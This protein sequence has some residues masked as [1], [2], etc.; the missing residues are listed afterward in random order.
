[1]SGIEATTEID[2]LRRE[3]ETV[4]AGSA[5]KSERLYELAE[6]CATLRQ[7][8]ERAEAEAD[9]FEA[10]WRKVLAGEH[11]LSDSYVRLR[12]ILGAMRPPDIH[13][14]SALWDYVENTAKEQV[15]ALQAA[16]STI[17]DLTA[18]VEKVR[19]AA[20]LAKRR[21]DSLEHKT[22]PRWPDICAHC[23]AD[24]LISAALGDA[25]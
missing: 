2:R 23:A 7:R 15:A 18:Q 5:I 24:E 4:Q 8:A 21:V 17:A 22:H 6:T 19:E 1:M 9:S 20:V 16:Q 14:Q 11:A 12:E 3:L 10:K 25:S 13:D